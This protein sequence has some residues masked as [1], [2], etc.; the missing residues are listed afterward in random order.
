MHIWM[1]LTNYIY[2]IILKN[3]YYFIA[4]L[5]HNLHDL[6]MHYRTSVW[7]SNETTFYYIAQ[8]Y[9]DI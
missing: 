8:S 2:Y 7:M 9:D 4:L 3:K 5:S 6:H 1:L